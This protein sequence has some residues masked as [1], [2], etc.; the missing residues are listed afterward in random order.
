MSGYSLSIDI[1]TTTTVAAL[2]GGRRGRRTGP[3]LLDVSDH[4]WMPSAVY[5]HPERGLLAGVEAMRMGRTDPSRL[6]PHPKLHIDDGGLPLGDGPVVPIMD[7]LAALIG[8]CVERAALRHGDRQPET[9]VL[10]YPVGWDS[11]RRHVLRRAGHRY[12]PTVRLIAEPIAAA[13]RVHALGAVPPR[14]PIAVYDLGGGS[15]DVAVVGERDGRLAV[16]ASDSRPELGG[17][18]L[19]E[20]LLQLALR[21]IRPRTPDERAVASLREDI[22]L[23]RE[24]LPI[25]EVDIPLPPP[26]PDLHLAGSE[27]EV[28]LEP[29]LRR[30]VD[31]LVAVLAAAGPVEPAVLLAGGA[32]R[33]PRC[34]E[35]I[36]QRLGVTP[37]VLSRREAAVCL[38]ALT[39]GLAEPPGDQTAGPPP[40]SGPA[41][42]ADEGAPAPEPAEP[43]E[44]PRR[45]WRRR[46]LLVGGLVAALLTVAALAY[47][48]VLSGGDV[49]PQRAQDLARDAIPLDQF[50]D[51]RA[52]PE[53]DQLVREGFRPEA[54]S[55]LCAAETSPAP[56]VPAEAGGRI[57]AARASLTEPLGQ[58]RRLAKRLELDAVYVSQESA[59]ALGQ[60][61]R[62]GVAAC[63]RD[64]SGGLAGLRVL[65]DGP[66]ELDVPE[67]RTW[68]AFTGE[69]AGDLAGG[70]ASPPAGRSAGRSAVAA[71][72][73]R[74]TCIVEVTGQLALR[75]CATTDQG[76][77]A[78]TLLAVRGL[79][80]MYERAADRR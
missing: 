79:N 9:I 3:T 48:S 4:P 2:S 37:L 49:S 40:E 76:Q 46:M 18:A 72:P 10:T 24:S 38:G 73:V 59:G 20:A 71:R 67:G 1:G 34:A 7:A 70:S 47:R 64:G 57:A 66:G 8:R 74:V 56:A 28:A 11:L 27:L 52:A 69:L 51:L 31:A 21:R 30:T 13:T 50:D 16:L 75:S 63:V 26:L 6:E 80:A 77:V 12:A 17:N 54:S 42:P 45:A 32:S 23:A 39:P 15:L 41:G 25:D 33:M 53:G 35:L 62:D 65:A 5:L 55:L 60:Q 78:T 19:D 14:T 29:M 43:S 58:V 61:V 36:E 22:R 68:A 44:A